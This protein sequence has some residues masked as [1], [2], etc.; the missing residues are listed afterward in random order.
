M[1]PLVPAAPWFAVA[2]AVVAAAA[3]VAAW[4]AV[5]WQGRQVALV[6]AGAMLAIVLADGSPLVGLGIGA[7]LLISAMVATIG[8]RG[9]PAA[10]LCVQRA[11]VALVMAVCALE[12]AA[13]GAPAATTAGHGHGGQALSGILPIIV[14]AGVVGVVL[15]TLVS[16]WV[17]EPVH[18]KRAARMIT[19]ES[20]ALAAGLAVVCLGL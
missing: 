20:W 1:D 6:L 7:L 11:V 10:A 2:A 14:V 16:E 5:P 4:K 18:D 9:T 13:P 17:M 12:S 8:V 3:C 15:W 19:I